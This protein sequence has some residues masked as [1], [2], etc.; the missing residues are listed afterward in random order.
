M[1]EVPI[2]QFKARC[3]EYVR[4]VNKTKAPILITRFGVPMA[5]LVPAKPRK[6]TGNWLGCMKGAAQITGD[7]VSPIID[8]PDIEAM[9]D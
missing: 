2:S 9:R 7:I 5:E 6:K 4:H 1:K 8:L 3:P